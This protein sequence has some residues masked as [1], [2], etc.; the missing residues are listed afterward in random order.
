MPFT[1]AEAADMIPR[2]SAIKGRYAARA[3][4]L[5]NMAIVVLRKLDEIEEA[6]DADARAM[7]H[8]NYVDVPGFKLTFEAAYRDLLAAEPTMNIAMCR[9]VLLG[10]RREAALLEMQCASLPVSHSAQ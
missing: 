6:M 8:P 7:V 9:I 2:L 3:R 1:A 5:A 10:V 4:E